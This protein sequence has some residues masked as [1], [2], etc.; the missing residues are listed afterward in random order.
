MTTATKS[1]A[2]DPATVPPT[3]STH[4]R[5]PHGIQP[6]GQPATPGAAYA[7][8]VTNLALDRQ[9]DAP[10]I[11]PD[12][13]VVELRKIVRHDA[14]GAYSLAPRP[15][16][17]ASPTRE[18]VRP[19]KFASLSF[20]GVEVLNDALIGGDSYLAAT[21]K[22][23][24]ESALAAAEDVQATGHALRQL[25]DAVAILV[26]TRAGILASPHDLPWE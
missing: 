9:R 6:N 21:D 24:W 10:Q 19:G 7:G 16:V 5:F 15:S 12:A 18:P 23:L 20:E 11:A 1:R 4:N 14:T 17:R 8:I 2:F 3:G 25:N 13:K 26:L 22:Q